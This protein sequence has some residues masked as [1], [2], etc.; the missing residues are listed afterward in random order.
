MNDLLTFLSVPTNLL[1][2][3]SALVAIASLSISL[4]SFLRDRGRL[5]VNV[6][7]WQEVNLQTGAIGKY[8]I[9]IVIVNSGR[10]SIT[11]D[12]I[13]AFPRWQMLRRWLWQ[14][15]PKHFKPVGFFVSGPFVNS[16]ILDPSGAPR[17]L[18]EGGIIKVLLP[19][20][21]NPRLDNNFCWDQIHSFYV[22]DST[23][24]EHF[25]CKRVVRKFIR[26]LNQYLDGAAG[27]GA[28]AP[29]V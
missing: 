27:Q 2:L 23:G 14:I 7:V 21:K 8:F 24:R 13:G 3:S 19:L 28:N 20:S 18:Q 26:Y 22:S 15:F 6:G 9:R 12:S 10:R 16:A 11:V 1:S 4:L 29:S 25:A 5:D 17:V